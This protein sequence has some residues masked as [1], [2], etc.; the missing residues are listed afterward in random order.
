VLLGFWYVT[1]VSNDGEPVFLKDEIC[2]SSTRISEYNLSGRVF[3]REVQDVLW[4][5]ESRIV[6]G[7]D[8]ENCSIPALRNKPVSVNL[9][10][11]GLDMLPLDLGDGLG[12]CHGE[13]PIEKGPTVGWAQN[14]V[15]TAFIS[16]WHLGSV[17]R[18]KFRWVK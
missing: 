3:D 12:E 1:R 6:G 13:P 9:C 14:P 11:S 15:Y 4:R 5:V 2:R 8:G 18:L 10:D 17:A 7:L 16:Q